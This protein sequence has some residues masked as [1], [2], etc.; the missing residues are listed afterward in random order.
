MFHSL[1][2]EANREDAQ[3][4]S[5]LQ[6]VDD[7]SLSAMLNPIIRIL[8]GIFGNILSIR[9]EKHLARIQFRL[10]SKLDPSVTTTTHDSY[11]CYCSL[12]QV[13]LITIVLF[14]NL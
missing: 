3:H 11:L 8:D 14:H 4:L 5:Q 10:N 2:I 12:S 9:E 1:N 6:L 13:V 7:D